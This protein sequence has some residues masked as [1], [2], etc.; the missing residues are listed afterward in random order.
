[1]I[2]FRNTNFLITNDGRVFSEMTNKFLKPA[3][4]ANG[5]LRYAFKYNDKHTTFKAHRLVAECYLDN[6]LNKPQVNHK[7]GNKQNNNVDNLEW[8]TNKENMQHAI[9]NG[10]FNPKD[11]PKHKSIN[12]TIKKGELNGCS[13]LTESEVLEIRSKFKPRVYTREMLALEYNVK[14]STIKDVIL[15]KSWKHI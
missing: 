11:K 14:A 3:K 6:P 9:E 1:M 12:K 7:D 13:K 4:D 2:R 10:L 5:Y 8:C 15:R